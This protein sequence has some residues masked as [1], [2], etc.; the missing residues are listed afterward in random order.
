ML[1]VVRIGL[2]ITYAL[3]FLDAR[4]QN[5]VKADSIR[6]LIE[7]HD[8]SQIE[9]MHAYYWL[10][11]YSSSPEEE[12][13]YGNI[14][15]KLAKRSNNQEY[16]IRSNQRIGVAYRLMGDLGK[17]L[18]H[19]FES[20]NEA[21]IQPEY[22]Q[23]L[24]D[25]YAEISTCYT[26]N[27]DSENALLY[28]L[29]TI[30]ILRKTDR[31]RT[32][33]LNLLNIGYD[34]YLIGKYDSAMTYYQESEPILKEIG[35]SIGQAYLIGNR[36]L[37]YWKKGDKKKA[38]ED[39][40]EAIKMLVPIGDRY[41]MADYYNKLGNIFLEENDQEKAIY[42]TM[43]GLEMATEEGLKEQMRDA[44]YLLFLLYQNTGE[45]KKAIG[46]QTQYNTYKDSIQNLQTTQQLSNLRVRFEVGQKQAEVNLL[47]A[48]KR[49]NQIIMITGGIVL[50]VVI[51]VSL[52][53]YTQSKSKIR[54]N[55]QLEE[56][57][58][59]LITLN[60]TKDKFF[61]IISH[62]LRGPVNNLSGLVSIAKYILG[63][64]RT[65]E[66]SEMVD[67]MEDSV[68]HLVKLLDSLLH[69]ALQQRGHFPYS[70]ENI[71]LKNVLM[72]VTDIFRDIAS[73]KNIKLDFV[74][75]DDFDVYIDK[76]TTTAIFRNLLNNAIK[77][78][79]VDS[80]IQITVEKNIE[81]QV[82][83]IKVIDSGVGIPPD[84]LKILFNLNENITT[85]G[86]MGE[87]GLGLGLQLVYE[88]IQLNK[89]EIEV[90][91]KERNGTTFTVKLPLS[92][93]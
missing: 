2:I 60:N 37:V 38:K 73:S 72:E 34:Y 41:G 28:G 83:I 62:D 5:Q 47:L 6:F 49:S 75:A 36:A 12:L 26:Q 29:K 64:T 20:A 57:K 30:E 16:L 46:Y 25:I 82:G 74:L 92:T 39:L 66:L 22:E 14:L 10:S 78:T 58:D 1:S 59:A 40:N 23:Y 44:S 9:E 63:D 89:A 87:T 91:S 68:S 71:S 61:S 21:V 11:A 27:G 67:K 43:K 48:Q 51:I 32:L 56:Q 3:F 53:I 70:P 4:S 8:L 84:K 33:A 69:W 85:K 90:E 19:L 31:K 17:A 13:K 88:F 65:D 93:Q 86:T 50:L 18:R 7:N 15:L 35:M 24:A 54:L 80:Q 55:R 52:L 76:N 45:Y 79:P 77:F 81:A 42:Y